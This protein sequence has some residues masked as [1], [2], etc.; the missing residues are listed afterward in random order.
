ADQV[1]VPVAVPLALIDVVV[2]VTDQV[3]SFSPE[4]PTSEAVPPMFSVGEPVVCV[5]VG[6]ADTGL[7]ICTVGAPLSRMTVSVTVV[8]LA[9]LSVA[10]TVMTC[11][12]KSML[13]AL[14]VL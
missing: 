4:A 8:T 14:S 10:V 6:G 11:E 2:F 13:M 12:P 1:A 7:V 5:K 3:T 9:T